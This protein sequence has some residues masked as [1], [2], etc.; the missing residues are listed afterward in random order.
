MLRCPQRTRFLS[1]LNLSE[2]PPRS[3][4]FSTNN[5]HTEEGNTNIP[6]LNHKLGSSWATPRHLVDKST[7][8]TNM[9]EIVGGDEWSTLAQMSGSLKDLL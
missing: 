9:N 4:W 6:K 8:V 1:T 2:W 7:R 5:P 3:I